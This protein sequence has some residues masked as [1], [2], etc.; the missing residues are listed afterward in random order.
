MEKILKGVR[1]EN[2]GNFTYRGARIRITAD[3]F[4]KTM[5]A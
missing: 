3:F 5:Q 2:K 1:V 4:I